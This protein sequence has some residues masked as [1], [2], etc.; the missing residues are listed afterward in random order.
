MIPKVGLV[1]EPAEFVFGGVIEQ[2][3]NP[4]G[5]GEQI[6]SDES[7]KRFRSHGDE[8]SGHVFGHHDG[9]SGGPRKNGAELVN[10]EYHQ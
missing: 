10:S 4:H 7:Q 3:Q 2:T 6:D 8:Q 1:G 5:D 9:M